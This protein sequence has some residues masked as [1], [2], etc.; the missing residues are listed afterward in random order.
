M[1]AGE[2]VGATLRHDHVVR[3]YH[4]VAAWGTGSA[5]I[6]TLE[7]K[8]ETAADLAHPRLLTVVVVGA[9]TGRPV[10]ALGLGC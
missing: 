3:E 6:A 4:P 1:R 5:Q 7:F 9:A 10:Q 8:P 2:N